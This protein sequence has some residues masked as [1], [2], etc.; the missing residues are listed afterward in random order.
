[1]KSRLSFYP[2]LRREFENS[3]EICDVINK[4]PSY[5]L[6]RLNGKNDFSHR[7]KVLIVKYLG[8][9]ESQLEEICRKE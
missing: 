4:S 1:M 5:V 9:D 7:D 2:V 3:Q 6:T 8:K